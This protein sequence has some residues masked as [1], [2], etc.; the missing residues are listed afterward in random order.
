MTYLG[1]SGKLNLNSVSQCTPGVK[2]V[3]YSCLVAGR[4]DQSGIM[5]CTH[6]RSSAVTWCV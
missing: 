4:Y 5:S 2:S 6:R 1:S 3:I